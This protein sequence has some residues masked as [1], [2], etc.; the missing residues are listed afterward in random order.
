[1][2]LCI[3]LSSWFD[4]EDDA[5]GCIDRERPDLVSCVI[6]CPYTRGGLSG[7][8]DASCHSVLSCSCLQPPSGTIVMN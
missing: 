1:M 4:F 3:L 8:A 7:E 5:P 6:S 2:S